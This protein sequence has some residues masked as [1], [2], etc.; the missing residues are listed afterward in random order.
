MNNETTVKPMTFKLFLEFIRLNAKTASAIPFILG[1]LY[2][3]YYF[4]SVD[5]L[6]SLI[7]FIAQMAIAFFVTGFNNVQ[8]YKL[9]V[10]QHYRDT[11]NI[12]GREHLSPQRALNLMLTFL[13][14]ACGLGLILVW[15]TNL[16]LL[17]MGGAGIFV[18]IF[19]TFGPIPFS[20]FP[21]GELLSGVA[22]GFGVFFITIYVNVAPERLLGLF[23]DWPRFMINGNLLTLIILVLVGLPNIFTVANVM[24]ADNMSDL[25]QD[26]RNQR[27]TLPYYLGIKRA[28]WLYDALLYLC[29][30]SVTVSAILRLLPPESLLVWLVLPRIRKNSRIFHREQIKE[31][32][33]ETAIQNLMLF[34]G[35]QIGA[36]VV[37]ILRTQVFG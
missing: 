35:V 4:Q 37:A 25:P 18:T 24:F 2:S 3:I 8:D 1:L 5:W 13:V 14:V 12:I 23:F 7:Y 26:I 32:T 31:T 10:D 30:A 9:A 21:L 22:E 28:L 27:Y 29:F 17:F 15:R 16:L 11:Y 34:Q 20:R 19:Y 36:L 33:F 6:N